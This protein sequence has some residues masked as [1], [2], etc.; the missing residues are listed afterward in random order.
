MASIWIGRILFSTCKTVTRD[1]TLMPGLKDFAV[2]TLP[3]YFAIQLIIIFDEN[4]HY[5]KHQN[6]NVLK[7]R[8]LPW[9]DRLTA[10]ISPNKQID[11]IVESEKI[12][13]INRVIVALLSLMLLKL[14]WGR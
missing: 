13:P 2:N 5:W 6:E 8:D 3:S 14:L 1:D 4:V 9:K 7:C 12:V 10:R 11:Y